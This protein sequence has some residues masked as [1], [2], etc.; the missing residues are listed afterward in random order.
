MT[1]DGSSTATLEAPAE[2]PALSMTIFSKNDCHKCVATERL[3]ERKG[4]PFTEINVEED[5]A[6]RDEFG[7]LTPFEYVVEKYGREMPVVVIKS[8]DGWVTDW[9]SGGRMDKWTETVQ[10]FEA[11]N[12]IIPEDERVVR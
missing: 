12:L 3:F 5:L 2:A 6:P 11:E 7:G 9:W 1:A 4:V 8:E 10:N